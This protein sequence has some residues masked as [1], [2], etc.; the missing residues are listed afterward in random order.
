M[1]GLPSPSTSPAVTIVGR[2]L[3]VAT[4]EPAPNAPAS[5]PGCSTSVVPPAV[6][7]ATTS[8]NVSPLKS[9]SANDGAPVA[10]DTPTP[11]SACPAANVPSPRPSRKC[12]MVWL[13]TFGPYTREPVSP[14]TMSTWPSP[15]MSVVFR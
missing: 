9:A 5:E 8:G 6:A 12:V 15:S 10:S 2:K 1:S 11:G 3:S 4:T 14:T 7:G 13:F